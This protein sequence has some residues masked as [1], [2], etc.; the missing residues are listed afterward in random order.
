MIIYTMGIAS[1]LATM[2]SDIPE[3][4]ISDRL[5]KAYHAFCA[6]TE[7]NIMSKTAVIYKSKT[8]FTR[9]YAQWIAEET[10]V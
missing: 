5:E 9:K 3:E 1:I 6:Q 8:G 10:G 2:G 7:R 4:E